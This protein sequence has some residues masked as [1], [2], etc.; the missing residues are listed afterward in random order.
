MLDEKRIL[1]AKANVKTYLAE[2]FLVKTSFK[3]IIFETYLRNHRESLDVAENLYQTGSSHLWTVVVSYYS[4]F[5]IANAV[6]YRKGFKIGH[7]LAHKVTADVLIDLVRNKLKKS[8]LEEYE[9]L[10]EEALAIA[11]ARADNIISSF[12]QE[13]TK[14]ALFQ[15]ETTDEIKSSKAATSF[16]RAKE[17]SFEMQKLL[18]EIK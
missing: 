5:Y 8:L 9:K 16:Q 11:A 10:Q 4:M 6:I 14:R 1:E 18:N 3:P 15:Y 2:Q 17:F 13:R 12:D 7:K